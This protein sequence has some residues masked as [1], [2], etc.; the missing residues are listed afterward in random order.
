M[1]KQFIILLVIIAVAYAS[2]SGCTT[3][4]NEKNKFIGSWAGTYSWAG[5][6]SRKVPAT[7]TFLSD[8]TYSA[9]LPLIRDNGTWDIV[10]GKLAKTTDSNP[11]VLY[12]Y[13]FSDNA[14]SLILTSTPKND[15]WNLTKQ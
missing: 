12:S 4:S 15:Q 2:L 5:N 13:T 9:T 6:L 7:F 11:A 14:T 1:K 3:S 10:N 8:G